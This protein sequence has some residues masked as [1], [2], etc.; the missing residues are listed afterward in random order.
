TL[1]LDIITNIT[2]NKGPK[3]VLYDPQIGK[4]TDEMGQT[5]FSLY[6]TWG[7]SDPGENKFNIQVGA[8]QNPFNDC[9]WYGGND[10]KLII[11]NKGL[12]N[13]IIYNLSQCLS[14]IKLHG[15]S[16]VIS[17]KAVIV[18]GIRKRSI[19]S[20]WKKYITIPFYIK[21]PV[22]LANKSI[23]S[24]SVSGLGQVGDKV[25]I[26]D[27]NQSWSGQVDSDGHFSI[28][29]PGLKERDTISITQVNG[30]GDKSE[31]DPV[32]YIVEK[33]TL[34]NP[35]HKETSLDKLKVY[36]DAF[37]KR[38]GREN[39]ASFSK[40][41]NKQKNFLD[42]LLTDSVALSEY[43]GGGYASAHLEGDMNTYQYDN[44]LIP[45]NELKALRIWS[46]IWN[47]DTNSRKGVELKLAIATSLEFSN[48]V[49]VW[50]KRSGSKPI[51]P[52][53]RYKDMA[54]AYEKGI[55]MKDISSYD[56]QTM[57]NI[58]N[59]S[60]TADDAKWLREYMSKN[61]PNMLNRW[62]ITTGYNLLTYRETNPDT[63]ASVFGGYFY[64]IDPT[65][66]DV[67][68]YG[69]VCGA[70]SKFSSDLARTYGVP[71]FPVGQ[72]GHCA[73]EYLDANHIWRLGYDVFG[74]KQTGNYKS[75]FPLIAL[76]TKLSQTEGF[77][78]SK[79]ETYLAMS[80]NTEQEAMKHFNQATSVSPLN[81][82]AWKAEI[83]Y[84]VN[85]NASSKQLKNIYNNIQYIF[86]N[87]P[88]IKHYLL[89]AIKSKLTLS[90]QP[91]Y[92][93]MDPSGKTPK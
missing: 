19:P 46:N 57:R 55:L 37:E 9:Y 79:Y 92:I 76:D 44:P 38:I 56:V 1:E 69:G 68:K 71:A 11:D 6:G 18:F 34:V 89:Q 32:N 75:T 8:A 22:V 12:L 10:D 64:G 29:T 77:N 50:Y 16:T 28:S 93:I 41:K 5:D 78:D 70:M 51:D 14:S 47:N 87:Y 27:G 30:T 39:L 82:N 58:V 65:I 25:T 62:D 35:N 13:K 52:F 24:Q 40:E 86:A 48:G 66:R 23:I 81:Y 2:V 88:I 60:I 45:S 20:G 54:T 31:S 59:A 84:L 63:G 80:S 26:K 3:Y 15:I 4:F 36:K 72:P 73:F 53:K 83:D 91:K 33:N 67:I 17:N 74:W 7:S 90:Q 49:I 43:L 21:A 85:H 61:H 42:W